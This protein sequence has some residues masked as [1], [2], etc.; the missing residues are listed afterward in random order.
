QVAL[1]AA[2]SDTSHRTF[3]G[4]DLDLGLKVI[5]KWGA[6]K[7]GFLKAAQYLHAQLPVYYKTVS[8]LGSQAKWQRHG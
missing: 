5:E 1:Q 6:Q 8:P 2:D 4:I 3:S 7:T